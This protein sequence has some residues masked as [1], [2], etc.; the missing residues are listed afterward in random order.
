MT[1][2]IDTALEGNVSGPALANIELSLVRSGR[3]QLPGNLP[4][5]DRAAK[6]A[7]EV[8]AAY[9]GRTRVGA[10]C[11][12][13]CR[14]K[15]RR[16]GL[17]RSKGLIRLAAGL[18]RLFETPRS[19]PLADDWKRASRRYVA[20]FTYV[21][22]LRA[23]SA[24]GAREAHRQRGHLQIALPMSWRERPQLHYFSGVGTRLMCAPSVRAAHHFGSGRRV[25]KILIIGDRRRIRLVFGT[26]Q[27]GITTPSRET[28]SRPS[29][30]TGIFAPSE[31]ADS[32]I[33]FWCKRRRIRPVAIASF[34][35]RSLACPSPRGG[36]G[37]SRR[38]VCTQGPMR[39]VAPLIVRRSWRNCCK[40]SRGR[41][42]VQP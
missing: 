9:Q 5:I 23:L 39:S 7:R 35:H 37:S 15:R 12:G 20:K 2:W 8:T 26:P 41:G 17:E 10:T 32:D 22:V 29:W 3:L 40:A 33:R 28:R 27:L 31:S 16:G 34:A 42:P 19:L 18:A 21:P 25:Q 38:R 11:A 14:A 13:I 24:L 1:R 4:C 6:G 30:R 36:A